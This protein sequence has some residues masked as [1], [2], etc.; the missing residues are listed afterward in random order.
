MLVCTRLNPLQQE[1]ERKKKMYRPGAVSLFLW[2]TRFFIG[3]FFSFI[4]AKQGFILIFERIS[5]RIFS[6]GYVINFTLQN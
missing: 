1:I 6:L 5:G 2:L 4:A 3:I